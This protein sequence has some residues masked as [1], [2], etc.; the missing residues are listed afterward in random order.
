MQ[1]STYNQIKLH[2]KI[3]IECSIEFQTQ[4][5][6]SIPQTK[7]TSC[8]VQQTTKIKNQEDALSSYI[9]QVLTRED[10]KKILFPTIEGQCLNLIYHP[11]FE[12][13]S[14]DSPQLY[15]QHCLLQA[16]LLTLAYY[17]REHHSEPRHPLLIQSQMGHP[18]LVPETIH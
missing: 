16:P 14:L 3:E 5:S 15:S 18:S 9:K 1:Y 10:L 2:A 6:K 7:K 11:H 12:V 17:N 8:L 4:V 13:V